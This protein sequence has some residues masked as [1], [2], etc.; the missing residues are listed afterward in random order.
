[1]NKTFI[2]GEDLKKDQKAY[3]VNGEI[4][5]VKEKTDNPSD[6]TTPFIVKCVVSYAQQNVVTIHNADK[7]IYW[8][9]ED[10]N[11]YHSLT[12]LISYYYAI[13]VDGKIILDCRTTDQKW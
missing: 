10:E 2:V 8:K 4:H 11:L 12:K 3:I 7:S 1:M 9:G 13:F 5:A 6:I